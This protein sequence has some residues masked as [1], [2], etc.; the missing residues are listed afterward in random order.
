MSK[1]YGTI[2]LCGALSCYLQA[3]ALLT[4]LS[5]PL[6]IAQTRTCTTS[7]LSCAKSSSKTPAVTLQVEPVFSLETVIV[8]LEMMLGEPLGAA[9]HL[10]RNDPSKLPVHFAQ[11]DL[12]V[13]R[14]SNRHVVPIIIQLVCHCDA[15][16]QL[17]VLRV[18]NSLLTSGSSRA[19][20][21]LEECHNCFPSVFELLLRTSLSSPTTRCMRQI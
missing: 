14:I 8:L 3:G 5:P 19:A 9:V 13:L 17:G 4:A 20:Q 16:T 7:A 6:M 12:D 1:T 11:K 10:A 18:F 21:N 15:A 2:W